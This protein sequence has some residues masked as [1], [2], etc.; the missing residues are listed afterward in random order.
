VARV[1]VGPQLYRSA[2]DHLRTDL[3]ALFEAGK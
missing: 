1:S 3:Q 2:L